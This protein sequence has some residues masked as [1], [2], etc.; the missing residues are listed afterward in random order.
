MV[1]LLAHPVWHTPA[2]RAR[3][4]PVRAPFQFC[5]HALTI[6]HPKGM[7]EGG[8]RTEKAT[9]RRFAHFSPL[10]APLQRSNSLL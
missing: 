9:A 5:P 6:D 1:V 7:D 4:L 10:S 3:L 2:P 8:E